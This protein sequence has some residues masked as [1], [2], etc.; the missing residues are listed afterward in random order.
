MSLLHMNFRMKKATPHQGS[1]SSQMNHHVHW[2]K[3]DRFQ[4]T[5][6]VVYPW[7][8]AFETWREYTYE[9]MPRINIR[10]W[11]QSSKVSYANT[12][13]QTIIQFMILIRK[14]ESESP[15]RIEQR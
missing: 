2:D 11:S 13:I 5:V 8:A 12:K 6:P 7:R 4:N 14:Y 1:L 9:R 15:T 10:Y 3:S